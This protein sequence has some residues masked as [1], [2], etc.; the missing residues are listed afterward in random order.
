MIDNLIESRLI[1]K[2]AIKNLLYLAAL[3]INLPDSAKTLVHQRERAFFA[4]I[5][6][7]L[8]NQRQLKLRKRPSQTTIPR[9]L[10]ALKA[11]N[12]FSGYL[13]RDIAASFLQFQNSDIV[14]LQ[15]QSR[16]GSSQR[17]LSPGGQ[18]FQVEIGM[19]TDGP[20][21]V[22]FST[23]GK[24][25]TQRRQQLAIKNQGMGGGYNR[26]AVNL[27]GSTKRLTHW[28]SLV[29]N[30]AYKACMFGQVVIHHI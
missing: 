30:H 25:Q 2:T 22:F 17:L 14:L 29:I 7:S 13:F 16:I 21:R 19:K 10:K 24:A 5:G 6:Y 26:I 23:G 18:L 28:Q 27:K 1:E 9:G 15:W 4:G 12:H 3:A 11:I 8:Q 20:H